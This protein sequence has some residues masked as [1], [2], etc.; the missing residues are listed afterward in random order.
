MKCTP[1]LVQK[2]YCWIWIAVDRYGKR[3]LHCVLGSRDTETGR[4]LWDAIQHETIERIMTDYWTP[5]ERFIPKELHTQ[6][7]AET[8]T[9][10]IVNYV[11]ILKFLSFISN[12]LE[13]TIYAKLTMPTVEG[14]NS[15]FRHFL[16][17]LR[18]EVK[19]LQ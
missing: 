15:L 9:V 8:Y 14:Y 7:K 2:N 18:R 19:V 4:Q 6:P 12:L 17:R 5:Y 10:G 3:F 11:E 1:I 16:A 13:S